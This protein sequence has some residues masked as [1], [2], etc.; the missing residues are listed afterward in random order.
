MMEPP[1]STHSTSNTRLLS[2]F[3]ISQSQDKIVGDG[4]TSVV[5]LAAE[6]FTNL[7]AQLSNLNPAHAVVSVL[8]QCLNFCEKV[9]NEAAIDISNDIDKYMLKTATTALSSK[10]ISGDSKK[11][12]EMAVNAIKTI[13]KDSSLKLIGIK[14]QRGGCVDD[15]LL[16]DGFAMKKCFAY[17]GAK[18]QPYKLSNC[19]VAL[20]NVEL[21]LK[22]ERTNAEVR[23]NSAAEYQKVVDAEW[24]ILFEKCEKIALSGANVVLS[25]MPVGDVATQ[26]F[27]DRNIYCGG[28][29]S[30]E[31]M[32]RAMKSCGGSVQTSLDNLAD[33]LGAFERFEEIQVGDT[34]YT[35]FAGCQKARSCTIILRGG[36]EF[37]MEET[38]RSLHDALK[39]VQRCYEYPQVVTGGGA[40]EM[41]LS[42]ALRKWANENFK[43]KQ[44][45]FAHEIA[46]SFEVIPVQLAKNCGFDQLEILS[47]L[48]SL[49]NEGKHTFGVNI[50]CPEGYADNLESGVLEPADLC[51][52]KLYAVFESILMLLLVDQTVTAPAFKA[53]S[54]DLMNAK[55]ALRDRG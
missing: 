24:D 7:A 55:N 12:A 44:L 14:T 40:I 21:E 17:A 47:K 41:H 26:Y 27:A 23:I 8:K 52:N 36:S 35:I 20:L 34:R 54:Q 37:F 53:E 33:N 42:A 16:I 13:G 45:V 15:S 10:L 38:R 2:S 22:G 1:F 50:T 18:S 4:T 9:V 49:H 3:E 5:L 25:K 6:A 30:Q 46:K 11:F 48:R 19:K 28:R 43:G 31:D 32:H 39:V 29:V 51:R